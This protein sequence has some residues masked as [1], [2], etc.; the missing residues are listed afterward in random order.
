MLCSNGLIYKNNIFLV[1]AIRGV[2]LHKYS[3]GAIEFRTSVHMDTGERAQQTEIY[4]FSL[5]WLV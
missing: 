5:S 4:F 1:Q 2:G 3:L